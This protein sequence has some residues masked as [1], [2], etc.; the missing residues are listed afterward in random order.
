M[1]ERASRVLRTLDWGDDVA[2]GQLREWW[3]S[4]DELLRRHALACMSESLCPEIVTQVAAY[5]TN[6]LQAFAVERMIFGFSEP[7]HQAIMLRALVHPSADVRRAAADTLLWD[8]P[9]AAE[10]RLLAA[11]DDPDEDV[12]AAAAGTLRYYPSQ[13]VFRAIT[14]LRTRCPDVAAKQ[15]EDAY[16]DLRE[17]FLLAVT[18]GTPEVREHMLRWLEPIAQW[19]AFTAEE[20]APDD[21]GPY[22]PRQ[23]TQPQAPAV[24][25]IVASLTDPDTPLETLRTTLRSADW[26]ACSATE[27]AALRP[28]LLAHAD[29]F[30]R[31]TA[32]SAFKAWTDIDALLAMLT[33]STFLVR[34]SAMF[35]LGQI[36]A[37]PSIAHIA[38]VAWTHLREHRLRGPAA[39]EALATHVHHTSLAAAAA[40]LAQLAGS[41]DEP[42]ELRIAAIDHLS[43]GGAMPELTA[44]LPHLT[45]PPAVTWAFHIALLDAAARHRP[46]TPELHAVLEIDNLHLQQALAVLAA[47]RHGLGASP[48]SP[49]G[50]T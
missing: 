35:Q 12:V 9:I 18:A 21:D 31:D 34:K 45:A 10:T 19:L 41:P 40:R 3:S 46:P 24:D 17:S 37:D 30:V 47:S 48:T 44:L 6:P 13:R 28:L 22:V 20:L 16:H 2:A 23:P 15:V 1:R 50:A 39:W 49:S 36:P 8:E 5:D 11:L 25:Q 42:E 26:S 27:R 33:D 14:R 29:L 4:A 38:D 32:V 43:A 7:E